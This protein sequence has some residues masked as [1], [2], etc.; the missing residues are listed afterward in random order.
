MKEPTNSI[1][2]WKDDDGKYYLY[3]P[4][5]NKILNQK[6]L[7]SSLCNLKIGSFDYVIDFSS[8]TQTNTR[9]Y[10]VRTI[11]RVTNDHVWMF[12][13]DMQKWELFS[14]RD[15]MKIEAM[16]VTGTHHSLTIN[17]QI[18]NGQIFSFQFSHVA[19]MMQ[20]NEDTYSTNPMKRVPVKESTK[21]DSETGSQH[22]KTPRILIHASPSDGK[23]AEE[24]LS[25][26]IDS[27]NTSKFIDVQPNH[28]LK[29][30]SLLEW[31]IPSIWNS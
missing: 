14:Q 27:L 8:M 24:R 18:F 29:F 13:N 2:V 5:D 1:W 17:G 9:T 28:C 26:C 4:E 30:L 3:Q 12:K 19:N 15:S 25:S 11:K 6:S 23:E 7:T 31:Y 20:I 22:C 10:K 16:Y 21:N